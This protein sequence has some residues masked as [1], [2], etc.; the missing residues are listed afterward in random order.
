MAPNKTMIPTMIMIFLAFMNSFW[1]HR[2]FVHSIYAGRTGKVPSSAGVH[3]RSSL[4]VG[5]FSIIARVAH[6]NQTHRR[7][8]NRHPPYKYPQFE[9]PS[10][11]KTPRKP[12]F[13]FP[14]HP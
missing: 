4:G 10:T 6:W 12:P 8:K 5:S 11:N 7:K 2:S 14:L 3:A 13:T 1:A 9:K